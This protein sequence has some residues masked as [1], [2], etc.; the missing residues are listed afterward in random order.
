MNAVKF[1]AS[2]IGK[3]IDELER[4]IAF[5][6]SPVRP[7]PRWLAIGKTQLQ[8]GFMA[9]TRAIAKPLGF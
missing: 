7:D 6:D 1:H 3:H 9:V 8:Q 5:S 2:E 4:K